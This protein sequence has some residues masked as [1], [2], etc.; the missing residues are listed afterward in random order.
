MSVAAANGSPY[1]VRCKRRHTVFVIDQ[2]KPY[3]RA[4]GESELLRLVPVPKPFA[5]IANTED[6]YGKHN[7]D[8]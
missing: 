8:D 5:K 6:G 1:S 3:S 7:P 4:V 2:G